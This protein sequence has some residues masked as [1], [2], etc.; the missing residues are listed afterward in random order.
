MA[1]L[2]GH[3]L[4]QTPGDSEGQGNLACCS[5]WGCKESDNLAT[6]QQWYIDIYKMKYYSAMERNE[7]L[8]YNMYEP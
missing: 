2:K 7:I 1:E 5:P 8:R 3:K 6:E 4:N